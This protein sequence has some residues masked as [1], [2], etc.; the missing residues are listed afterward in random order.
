[1]ERPRPVSSAREAEGGRLAAVF[2]R[3]SIIRG[4]RKRPASSRHSRRC[5]RC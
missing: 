4:C 2:E 1:V 5:A 3:R